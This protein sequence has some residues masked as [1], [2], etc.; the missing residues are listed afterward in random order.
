MEKDRESP[1]THYFSPLVADRY[2]R[3]FGGTKPTP[4][5]VER[6]DRFVRLLPPGGLVLDA[7]CGTGRF[8]PF[9][10]GRGLRVVGIDNSD[11]ML[12]K[13]KQLAPTC[14]FRRMD[15]RKLEFPD[16]TFDGVASIAV[17]LHLDWAGV[18]SFLSE[19]KRVLKSGGMLHIATRT[20]DEDRTAV[21]QSTDGGAML[22]H[23]YGR[24]TLADALVSTGFE[25]LADLR[26]PDDSGRH[27]DYVYLYAKAVK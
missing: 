19:A 24:Q 13:A 15:I 6:F 14:E 12:D 18:E 7:G 22:V 20:D 10:V 25:I 11:A 16:S 27:F 2:A 5:Q 26:L 3:A 21:E 8:E 17:V 23:Y 1:E 4:D 9:F